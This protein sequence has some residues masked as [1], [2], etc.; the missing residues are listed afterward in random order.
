MRVAI[1]E[2]GIVPARWRYDPAPGINARAGSPVQVLI[3]V[4][5]RLASALVVHGA[6]L[7]RLEHL[8]EHQERPAAEGAAEPAELAIC[9]G[10]K[11]MAQHRIV[12]IRT[13]FD[14]D[15]AVPHPGSGIP[16]YTIGASFRI[17]SSL[18]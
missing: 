16:Q 1:R 18:V 11:L 15:R 7:R 6:N 2:C 5:R 9:W 3:D 10:H 13:K 14:D 8:Y 4:A 17:A 12:M